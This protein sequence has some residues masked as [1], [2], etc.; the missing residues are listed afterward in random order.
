MDGM[1]STN[2]ESLGSLRD[3]FRNLRFRDEDEL[4]ELRNRGIMLVRRTCGGTSNYYQR[5]VRI[6]FHPMVA[7][8][9]EQFDREMWE[10]G[11]RYSVQ[12]LNT[13]IVQ[14]PAG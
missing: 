14:P 12:L 5:F 3:G 4:G 10:D 8:S 7:P 11:R 6:G 13:M 9:T 1:M 2:K